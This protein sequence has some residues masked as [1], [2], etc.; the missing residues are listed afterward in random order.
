MDERVTVEAARAGSRRVTVDIISKGG[1][2]TD[3]AALRGRFRTSGSDEGGGSFGLGLSIA[4]QSLEAMNATLTFL[5]GNDVVARIELVE[6]DG[7]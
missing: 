7:E 4:T 6:G 2:E 1:G 5:P 3:I